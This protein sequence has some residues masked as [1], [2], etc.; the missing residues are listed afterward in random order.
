MGGGDLSWHQS[1]FLASG[2]PAFSVAFCDLLALSAFANLAAPSPQALDGLDEREK[3]TTWAPRS[4]ATT[5]VTDSVCIFSACFSGRS[6]IRLK[7]RTPQTNTRMKRV[8]SAT[9]LVFHPGSMGPVHS[10]G[11]NVPLS[12]LYPLIFPARGPSCDF[13]LVNVFALKDV[14]VSPILAIGLDGD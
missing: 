14:I 1:R 7:F 6:L 10:S 2:L 13:R 3:Q 4:K 8:L 11:G 9:F 12:R 5:S